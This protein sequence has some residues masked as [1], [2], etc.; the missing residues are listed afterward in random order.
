MPMPEQYLCKA[1]AQIFWL[2]A[3]RGV[4]LCRTWASRSLT[5][6]LLTAVMRCGFKLG[7]GIHTH[8]LGYASG[9]V[10]VCATIAGGVKAMCELY[11][12]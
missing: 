1:Q 7:Q 11:S 8:N 9:V 3:E 5:E 10:R 12:V 6:V 4:Y 2:Y